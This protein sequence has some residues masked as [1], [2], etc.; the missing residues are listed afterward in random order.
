MN[1]TFGAHNKIYWKCLHVLCSCYDAIDVY[2]KNMETMTAM[3]GFIKLFAYLIPNKQWSDW[4][5]KF[6]EMDAATR[7]EVISNPTMKTYYYTTEPF[8]LENY[9]INQKASSALEWSWCLHEYINYKRRMQGEQISSVPFT[10]LR[11]SFNLKYIS[12]DVWGRP[13]WFV[14]HTFS[15]YSPPLTEER[16]RAWKA[17]AS[18][19]QFVLPCPICRKHVR[20]NML[21]LNIDQFMDSPKKLF[22]WTWRLHNT[23]NLSKDI[24]T[25]ALS[26]EEAEELYTKTDEEALKLIFL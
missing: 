17:F 13:T 24:K 2:E 6:I 16:K 1:F 12:K 10:D 11:S 9:I 8:P 5:A 26:L 3:V 25:R 14:L 18:S 15:L 23:V 4:M 19:L 7:T 20:E 21:A 22:Q